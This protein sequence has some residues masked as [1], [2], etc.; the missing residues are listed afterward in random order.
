MSTPNEELLVNH[1][2]VVVQRHYN[3]MCTNHPIMVLQK[4]PNWVLDEPV[5][6]HVAI[7]GWLRWTSLVDGR[8]K[9]LRKEFYK[10]SWSSWFWGE[11]AWQNQSFEGFLQHH[12]N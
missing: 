11:N 4:R 3:A 7:V 10:L 8:P 12:A 1:Q 2:Q 6:A 5:A 9:K